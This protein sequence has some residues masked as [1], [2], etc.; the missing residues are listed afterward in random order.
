MSPVLALSLDLDGTL[1]D[2]SRHQV[3]IRRTCGEVAAVSGLDPGDLL[4]ANRQVWETYWPEVED[5]WTLGAMDGRAVTFEAW[6]LTLG[7]CGSDDQAL[8][9][10]ATAA[11]LRYAAQ[12]LRLFDDAAALF[13]LLEPAVSLALISNGASDTQRS[14]LRVLG[15]EHRFDA[16]L[17]SGELGVAKPDPSIFCLAVERLGIG[18]GSAWHVGDSMRTDVAGAR[19]AGLTAVWL[20]RSETRPETGEPRPDHEIRSLSELAGLLSAGV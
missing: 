9:E 20:N 5:K 14:A 1:L 6:R 10:L 16:V 8:A 7:A 12:K 3:A 18:A 4:G 19:A 11:H 15:I 2:G 13:G 17:I